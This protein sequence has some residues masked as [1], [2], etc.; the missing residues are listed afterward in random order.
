[1]IGGLLALWPGMAL[2]DGVLDR[3]TRPPRRPAS[4]AAAP[5][6]AS[7]LPPLADVV[8]RAG[9]DGELSLEVF[10][11]GHARRIEGISSE[12]SKPPASVT[13]AVTAVYALETLGPTHRFAT[14]L[15]YSG[16]LQDGIASGD[17]ILAAGG[18][19]EL[20]TDDLADLAALAAAA[21]LRAVRGRFLVWPGPSGEFREIDAEQPDYLDYNPAVSGFALNFNRVYF[22]WRRAGGDYTLTLDARAERYQPATRVATI[23]TDNRDLPVYRLQE[24]GGV[25][26]WSVARG[27]LGDGGTRWLPVHQPAAY[28]GDVF[29]TLAAGAGLTLPAAQIVTEAPAGREIARVES[30]ELTRIVSGML[31]YS[32]NLTAEML[33]LAA[34]RALGTAP[35]NLRASATT[36]G[37]WLRTRTGSRARFVDHSGLSG[38]SRISAAEMV[39]FLADPR[40]QEL[41]R[42]LLKKVTVTDDQGNALKGDL[43]RVVAKTGTLN[44][45]SNLAGYLD[46]PGGGHYA[47]AIFGTNAARRL[48]VEG[49]EDEVPPGARTWRSHAHSLQA[50]LL[51]RWS[52]L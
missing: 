16:T 5:V 13:K 28:A 29:R 42:P 15:L 37:N 38:S 11:L 14:R 2:A 31:Y 8:R 40:S 3:A 47:F 49:S 4:A 51:R 52:R 20:D 21:G 35:R 48:A 50:A 7:D 45:A 25:E 18:D 26:K 39:A 30:R 41:L 10:D 17:V 32:T 43:P 22:E 34:S 9:F 44:F 12:N 1:M 36:M 24:R 19:P 27:A 6:A 33:G 46:A 23:E